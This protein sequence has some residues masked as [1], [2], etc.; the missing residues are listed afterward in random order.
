MTQEPPIYSNQKLPKSPEIVA[1]NHRDIVNRENYPISP[2]IYKYIPWNIPYVNPCIT[3]D[4]SIYPISPYP[5]CLRLGLH[6]TDLLQLSSAAALPL[7][8]RDAA[9]KA[10]LLRREEL[11]RRPRIAE[12]VKAMEMKF[13]L[14]AG[15][16][17]YM[18]MYMYV[19]IYMYIYMWRGPFG[20]ISFLH[21]HIYI[22]IH[23]YVYI[24]VYISI[25]IFIFIYIYIWYMID[26]SPNRLDG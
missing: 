9:L 25:L 3:G 11:Q 6:S 26:W 12:E 2:V 16:L 10:S 7:R 20:F 17:G 4:I 22:Y 23:R 19:Y 21:S 24:F 15:G 13:E 14:E 18:Y 8:R 5:Q 1:T